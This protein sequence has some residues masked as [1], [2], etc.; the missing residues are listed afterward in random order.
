[1]ILWNESG[2]HLDYKMK[3]MAPL[4]SWAALE[5]NETFS[6]CHGI[7]GTWKSAQRNNSNVPIL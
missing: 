3:M 2:V 4:T 1:M 5:K 7:N 6:C